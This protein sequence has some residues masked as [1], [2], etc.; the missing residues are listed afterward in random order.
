METGAH[1]TNTQETTMRT[2][3]FRLL[4]LPA[5][6]L[7]AA[8]CDESDSPLEPP[9]AA[10]ETP[11][12]ADGPDF[13]VTPGG[14]WASGYLLT[15]NPNS[16][17][18]TPPSYASYNKSG[19]A[20]NVRRPDGTTGRY[21]VTFTGLSAAVGGKSTVRVTAVGVANT[22]C[23]AMA[24]ALA[25]DKVEVRCTRTDNGAATN[26]AFSLAVL[27]KAADRAF[28]FANQ[29]TATAAYT[30]TNAG[31]WNPAGTTKVTRYNVG[32]YKVSFTNLGSQLTPDH[33]GHIQVHTVGAGKAYCKPS[34]WGGTPHLDITV[35]CLL[36]N[37][38]P[39]DAKF[40]VHF[41]RPHRHIAYAYAWRPEAGQYTLDGYSA[42][43]PAIEPVKVT[44]Q[45][46]GQYQVE[47]AG[48]DFYV[49]DWGNV[50]V[51]AVGEDHT[52]HCKPDDIGQLGMSVRCFATNGA[53][54]DVPFMALLGS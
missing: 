32:L 23:K 38:V 37:G 18:Y 16:W 6:G 35:Q 21:V 43:N 12:P 40:P 47:W 2:P 7:L 46:T 39:V 51:I 3:P 34:H 9:G 20:I 15:E 8:A 10:Q 13:D 26:S 31:T 45:G 54:A 44:R 5:L 22:S 52:G 48:V 17:S 1:P 19:G 50:Q 24:G 29:P 49:V 36:P 4:L 42:Y 11:V 14:R 33:G 28:A 30:A 27:G 25:S 41:Q 53:P